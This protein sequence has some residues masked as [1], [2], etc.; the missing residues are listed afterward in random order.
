MLHMHCFKCE[1]KFSKKLLTK[2]D[3]IP[4]NYKY[5]YENI[6]CFKNECYLPTHSVPL[7][8]VNPFLHLHSQEPFLFMNVSLSEQP[9]YGFKL[10]SSTSKPKI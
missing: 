5:L 6:L 4:G 3:T 7:K 10:H 8:K 9:Q 2:F 1:I